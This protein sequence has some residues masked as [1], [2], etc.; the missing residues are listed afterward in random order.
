S[1]IDVQT[2]DAPRFEDGFKMEGRSKLGY[3]TNGRG[4]EGLQSIAGGGP[5]FGFRVTYD[6]LTSQDYNAGGGQIVPSAYN[7]Q[8]GSFAV[9]YNFSPDSRLEFKG[10]RL[11]QH[12][13]QFPGLYFDI[14]RLDTESYALRYTCDNQGIF[15]HFQT[16][17]WYNDTT[18]NGDTRRGAKQAFL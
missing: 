1:F 9:G 13:V 6:L 4:W 8:N 10:F 18:A 2:F 14:N 7:S 15:D 12:D 16:D 3:N 11:Y 17:L 5:D